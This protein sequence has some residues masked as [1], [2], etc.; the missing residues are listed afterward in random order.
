MYFSCFC[1]S[2][3]RVKSSRAAAA[4]QEKALS[5]M[6]QN[7]RW[8]MRGRSCRRLLWAFRIQTT[9]MEP[10]MW[11][12]FKSSTW[13]FKIDWECQMSTLVSSAPFHRL[14]SKSKACL[15]QRRGWR[16]CL[17]LEPSL[18]LP[19][20]LPAQHLELQ[21]DF[22]VLDPPLLETSRN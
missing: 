7:M 3:R 18:E 11:E 10:W 14:R 12:R 17:L 8:P 6:R 16:T 9:K 1:F 2:Y 21:E 19:E 4:S 22:Q 13:S 20:P 5:L 15:I